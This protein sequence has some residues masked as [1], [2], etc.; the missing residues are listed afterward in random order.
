MNIYNYKP[1]VQ[2]DAVWNF[3]FPEPSELKLSNKK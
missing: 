2:Q 3:P 1:L